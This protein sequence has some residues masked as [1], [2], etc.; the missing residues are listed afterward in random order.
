MRGARQVGKT[1]LVREFSKEFDNYLELNLE[2]ESDINLFS[3][4]D[5]NKILNAAY[6]LKNVIPDNRPMLLFIDEI[7]ES[8]KAIQLLRYFYEEKPELYVIAAGSLLEFAFRK[9]P[10][11]PV[12]RIE[13]LYLHPL[14]FEEYLG[15]LNHAGAEE[16]LKTIPAPDY[17]HKILLDLFHEYG[18]VGGMPEA[19]SQYVKDKNIARLS[20]IY[21]RLWQAY[22]DDAGKYARNDSDRKVIQHII[23]SSPNEIDRIKFEHF[24]ESNY[25]SREVGEAFRS[26]SLARIVQLVYP[27]TAV[28]P[29][30]RPNLKKR[31]RL[32]FLDTGLLNSILLLQG[33]LITV[34][35]LN[36]FYR[37]KIVYHL[38]CQE[39]ISI[40]E[41]SA[42]IPHFWVREAKDSNSEV[43]LLFRHGKYLI[44][45]EVKSGSQGRLR[46]LHQFVERA[47][48]PYA[49][50]IYAGEFKVEDHHTPGG[51]PYLLMNL[52][53]YLGTKIAEYLEYFV[54]NYR[55]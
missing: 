11:F 32:Q 10:S 40:H 3:T 28:S 36:D 9:V 49:V 47:D 53:Y 14:N 44:P 33:D 4:D 18:I 55:L 48:H 45:I 1:T 51:K 54:N 8:P 35:D 38:V 16:A 50:R 17:A 43:D 20:G 12:G 15:A 22:K 29:P 27:T 37:G 13:Y 19:V 2:R 41:E 34:R 30:I 26:L 6:I 7:Q 39:F 46:S 21:N 23:D 5:I 24:G 42:Y 25:R 31:P 52:P